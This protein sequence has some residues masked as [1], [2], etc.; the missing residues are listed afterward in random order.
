MTTTK[1]CFKWVAIQD[2]SK[3]LG[4]Y[5]DVSVYASM[6]NTSGLKMKIQ[7]KQS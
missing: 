2:F 5:C 3:R 4:P 7:A 6:G 1:R